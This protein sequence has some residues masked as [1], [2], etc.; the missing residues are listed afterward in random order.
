MADFTFWGVFVLILV[1]QFYQVM[2]LGSNSR[3]PVSELLNY[4]QIPL[5]EK[6]IAYYFGI[7]MVLFSLPVKL[8]DVKYFDGINDF[9]K[10]EDEKGSRLFR[11]L[12]SLG[13]LGDE[14]KK[15]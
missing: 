10:I 13:N 11:F 5:D 3:E 1:L 15:M 2:G 14:S 8:I 7:V 9:L 12:T 4:S 6:M